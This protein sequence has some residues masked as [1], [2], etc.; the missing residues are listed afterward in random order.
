MVAGLLGGQDVWAGAVRCYVLDGALPTLKL[1]SQ[2]NDR[3]CFVWAGEMILAMALGESVIRVWDITKS[4]NYALSPHPNSDLRQR[5]SIV[6]ERLAY[7]PK[8]KLLAAGMSDGRIAIWK[9][10]DTRPLLSTSTVGIDQYGH[11]PKVIESVSGNFEPESCW[12]PQPIVDLFMNHAEEHLRDSCTNTSIGVLVWDSTTGVLAAS[13]GSSTDPA[14]ENLEEEENKAS[15]YSAFILRQQPLCANIGGGGSAVVQVSSQRLA[16]I[17][18]NPTHFV[19]SE[20][21]DL[22]SIRT[23]L[24]SNA[25][26]SSSFA[27]SIEFTE[28]VACVEE[29]LR[30]AFCTQVGA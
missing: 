9:Y 8:H 12:L 30:S 22:A 6:I 28:S 27:K 3:P 19:K 26:T 10:T 29:Q 11:F 21:P 5:S 25:T 23:A 4:D 16:V 24:S 20:A 13:Y 2:L 15:I 7:C 14:T 18:S 1:A 17:S